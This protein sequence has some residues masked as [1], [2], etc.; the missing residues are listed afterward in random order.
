MVM[1][2]WMVRTVR[3]LAASLFFAAG[4][5][6]GG[7]VVDADGS[8]ARTPH[9]HQRQGQGKA[10]TH[11][12]QQEHRNGDCRRRDQK[13]TAGMGIDGEAGDPDAQQAGDAQDREGEADGALGMGALDKCHQEPANP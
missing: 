3:P 12:R 5:E 1:P 7:L 8:Q 13:R 9:G 10:A 6:D 4:S 11:K 2:S